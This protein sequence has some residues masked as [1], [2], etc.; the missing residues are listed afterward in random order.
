MI[1]SSLGVIGG[2]N[3]NFFVEFYNI[4]C[5]ILQGNRENLSNE[6]M[7]FASDYYY[8]KLFLAQYTL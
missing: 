5:N 2:S 8:N 7:R 3:I 1:F 4:I 6:K